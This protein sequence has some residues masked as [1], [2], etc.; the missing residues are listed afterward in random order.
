MNISTCMDSNTDTKKATKKI[1][2]NTLLTNDL[3]H[4][5]AH[6]LPWTS[7]T[8]EH[9]THFGLEPQWN[10]LITVDLP[11]SK[12]A[13]SSWTCP[14]V[15]MK[16]KKCQAHSTFLF[17]ATVETRPVWKPAWLARAINFKSVP[18]ENINLLLVEITL[19][20]KKLWKY[21]IITNQDKIF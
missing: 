9:P 2:Q 8:A 14:S 21:R 6:Y 4:Q 20:L 16:K 17:I 1:L 3:P 7:P 15:F 12:T 13:Y 18:I 11:H 10:T 19:F 5:G